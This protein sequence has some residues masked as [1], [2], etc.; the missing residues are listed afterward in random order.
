[1]TKVMCSVEKKDDSLG[2]F[3]VTG[4]VCAYA[5]DFLLINDD[6]PD[7]GPLLRRSGEGVTGRSMQS[8]QVRTYGSVI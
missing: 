7:Q 4:G 8:W 3:K 2:C 6:V 5:A 1:M